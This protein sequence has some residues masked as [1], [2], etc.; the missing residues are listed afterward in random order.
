M[1]DDYL[2][3]GVGSPLAKDIYALQHMAYL[4]G[5]RHVLGVMETSLV[6]KR[7]R[8]DE[9]GVDMPEKIQLSHEIDLLRRMVNWTRVQAEL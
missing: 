2:D 4:D 6:E 3:G 1:G 8:Y 5:V 9:P 7:R